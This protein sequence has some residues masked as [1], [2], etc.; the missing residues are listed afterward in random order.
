MTLVSSNIQTSDADLIAA[1][2]AGDRGAFGQIVR[3][4][5]AMISGLVYAA[6]GDLHCSEDV[7]Q[8]TFISAWKSL[9][10][11]REA[12]KLP[13]WL[14]QI[15]RRRLGDISRKK[16]GNE[17]QFS[18]AFE[19][20][21]EPQAPIDETVTDQ[22]RE[23]LWK[24]LSRIPQPYRETLVL[25]YRQEQSTAQ[26]A[27]AME[28]S[29]ASVR[30]RLTR[31][32]QMLREEIAGA[33]ERN[34]ART[35]PN[36]QFTSQ[37]VAALPAFVAQSAGFGASAKGAAAFK[38]GGLLTIIM[39]WLAPLTFF[40]GLIFGTVQDIKASKT[41]RQ[42]K[43]MKQFYLMMWLLIIGWVV[44]F[45]MMV[46]IGIQ[47]HW[48][49]ANASWAYSIGGALF[50]FALFSLVVFTR[51][52]MVNIQRQEQLFDAP[53][54]KLA[55]WKR[56]V[57]TIPVVALCL[58]WMLQFAVSTNDRF[59]VNLISLIIIG[60]G[61]W[62]AWRMPKLQPEG[63][64]QQTFETFAMAI[65]AIITITNW[66]LEYWISVDYGIPLEQLK[67]TFSM[68]SVNVPAGILLAWICILTFLSRGK[69]AVT[70]P[71]PISAI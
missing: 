56:L 46:N 61:L 35:A 15:A 43:L 48:A 10:G 40:V 21:Q 27:A 47:Q 16:S 3:R 44:G 33:L 36:Q 22:E 7:A 6:C 9:S 14:C 53:F 38:G 57:F 29:E 28:T 60:Q 23:M 30:Q 1:S 12:S 59:S 4:Y 39:G 24:T 69:S 70:N 37:V 54:P 25:F 26:V 31:G 50:G 62:H 58:G 64:I 51:W 45:N 41:P 34:L 42:K 71:A 11:L 20:G 55:I 5:Q 49:L 32:R 63:Q 17:I 66:R 68:W 8:E 65:I 52:G 13:G 2:R 67:Q 19:S 18:K